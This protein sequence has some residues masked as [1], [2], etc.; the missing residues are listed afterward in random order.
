MTGKV[1][2][3]TPVKAAVKAAK[4]REQ[5]HQHNEHCDHCPTSGPEIRYAFLARYGGQL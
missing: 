4:P 5:E 3:K 2:T 1:K